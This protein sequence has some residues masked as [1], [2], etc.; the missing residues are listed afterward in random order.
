[1]QWGQLVDV[2][3]QLTV[4]LELSGTFFTLFNME[5]NSAREAVESCARELPLRMSRM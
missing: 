1:M 2:A 5:M 3:A 4:T